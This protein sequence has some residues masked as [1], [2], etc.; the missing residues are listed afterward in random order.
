MNINVI[1]PTK[2]RILAL[3]VI[4]LIG[5]LPL[6]SMHAFAAPEDNITVEYR[7]TE[8]ETVDIPETIT[9]FDREYRLLSTEDPVLESSLPDTR[10]YNFR[11]TGSMTP[12]QLAEYGAVPGL[13]ITPVYL[14]LE[15]E[16]EREVTIT[17]RTNDIDDIP[18]TRIFNVT[19]ASNAS[20]EDVFLTRSGVEFDDSKTQYD[21]W[22]LPSWYTA[23]V[24]YRGIETY[25]DIAYY[26]GEVTYS[27]TVTE[28]STDVYVIV[29]T[30]EPT[31]LTPP[32]TVV[33]TETTTTTPN[34][35]PEPTPEPVVEN[36]EF[37]EEEQIMLDSQVPL[38]PTST[39]KNIADGLTPLGGFGI[40]SA[41]S[42]LSALFSLAAVIIAII[43]IVSVILG[44]RNSAKLS[45]DNVTSAPANKMIMKILI[46]VLA[47]LTPITWVILDD[48][49]KP[50]IWINRYTIFVGIIFI[51]T[52][53]LF[54]VYSVNKG[55]AIERRESESMVAQTNEAAL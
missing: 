11:I 43:M 50:Q 28:G 40:T 41:W 54:I 30:Y 15:R 10:T 44:R 45:A 27:S 17:Q 35:T 34:T 24:V 18:L 51:L 2:I 48:L 47:V 22:G 16:V 1:K 36:T 38:S 31:D 33:T 9:Q 5:L 39:I 25:S 20:G 37:T 21:P 46:L 13:S 42:V 26:T 49:S 14:D 4:L 6:S 29:A 12:A 23:R 55:K 32:P 19:S 52:L 7:Y 53:A 3:A 8:G